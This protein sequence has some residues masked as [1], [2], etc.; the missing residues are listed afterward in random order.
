MGRD[1]LLE[2]IRF[3]RRKAD[4]LRSVP[5]LGVQ[6]L[7]S[8]QADLRLFRERVATL[9]FGDAVL[10]EHLAS[11]DLQIA[12]CHLGGSRE[13]LIQTWWMQMPFVRLFVLPG[14]RA[15]DRAAIDAAFA[16]LRGRLYD[17]YCL[18]EVTSN[19]AS[20]LPEATPGQ[21]PAAAPRPGPGAPRH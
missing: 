13:N 15:K 16:N 17:L 9:E 2:Y 10:R 12:P 1:Q 5:D 19:P 6:D 18:V 14:R 20:R 8:L 7:A 3:L 21:R 4:E 11:V